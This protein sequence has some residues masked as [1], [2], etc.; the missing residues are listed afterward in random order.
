MSTGGSEETNSQSEIESERAEFKTLAIIN[1]LISP[2]KKFKLQKCERMIDLFVF[3]PL[4]SKR[5]RMTNELLA[6]ND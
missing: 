4:V 2:N 5:Q 3:F 1:I 6:S